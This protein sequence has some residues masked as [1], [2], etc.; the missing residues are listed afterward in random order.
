MSKW[1]SDLWAG[2]KKIFQAGIDF[3]EDLI[4]NKLGGVI[5]K[6]GALFTSIGEGL[7]NIMGSIKEGISNA[8]LQKTYTVDFLTKKRVRNDG[9]VPK[10]YV[11]NSHEG[12]VPRDLFMQVQEEMIRRAN[13]HSSTNMKKRVYSSKYAL[14]SIVY[15]SKCG[16]IYRRIAWNNRGKHSIVWRC[17][18]RV[19]NGPQACDA[20]TIQEETLKKTVV[21]AINEVISGSDNVIET[22]KRNIATVLGASEDNELLKIEEEL[23]TLQK[24]LTQKAM[25]RKNYDDLAGR[26]QELMETKQRVRTNKAERA[27][28]LKRM[29]EITDFLEE[30]TALINEY[31]EQLTRR[32]IEKITVFDDIF[33]V[34]FKSGITVNIKR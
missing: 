11:E 34:R 33:E 24:E 14:S 17:C 25:A 12:I 6:I 28:E 22:V 13:L 9:I 2:V 23:T 21:N 32:L 18:N 4:V 8:L 16:E 10:Y 15:C 19:E 30:Q 1:F 26:I 5:K 7:S 20:E 27:G 29:E 3:I 31:D